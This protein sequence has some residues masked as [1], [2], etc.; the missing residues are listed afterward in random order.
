M[1]NLR[2]C[3]RFARLTASLAKWIACLEGPLSLGGLFPFFLTKSKNQ[4]VGKIT[5][6]EWHYETCLL[7]LSCGISSIFPGFRQ[8]DLTDGNETTQQ[9]IQTWYPGVGLGI[10]QNF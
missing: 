4:V 8:N 9:Q 7:A 6:L 5:A 1:A 3:L 2:Y 10:D